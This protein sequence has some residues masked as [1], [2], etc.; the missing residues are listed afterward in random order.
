M[1]SLRWAGEISTTRKIAV[2]VRQGVEELHIR[3]KRHAA[4][5]DA[6]LTQEQVVKR[7]QVNRSYISRLE[8]HPENMKLATLKKYALTVGM[9][10]EIALRA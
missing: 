7:M 9:R 6:G 2:R 1:R 10:V 3:A 4:R 8:N 5:K